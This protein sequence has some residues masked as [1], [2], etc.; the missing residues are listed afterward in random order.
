MEI[1]EIIS[2]VEESNEYKEW[3]S[4]NKN[5]YL[6]HVFTMTDTLTETDDKLSNWQVGYYNNDSEKMM[7]FVLQDAIITIFPEQDVFKKPGQE[8]L[9]LDLEKANMAFEDAKNMA[10][11][12]FN[13]RYPNQKPM[14]SIYILQNINNVGQV[15]NV[16]FFRNGALTVNVK[17]NS[18]NSELISDKEID[19]ISDVKKGLRGEK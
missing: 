3:S 17:I 1:K 4:K 16:T 19:L 13:D 7:T 18:E 2:K 15:W 14:K 10:L 5:T 12:L 9:E 11:G 8:I 6:A